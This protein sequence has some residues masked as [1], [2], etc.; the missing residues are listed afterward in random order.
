[1]RIFY[2][3]QLFFTVFSV[4]WIYFGDW[5]HYNLQCGPICYNILLFIHDKILTAPSIDKFVTISSCF[6]LIR[7]SQRHLLTNLLEFYGTHPGTGF[8]TRVVGPIWDQ[9]WVAEFENR[10]GCLVKGGTKINFRP[11]ISVVFEILSILWN[12]YIL[13]MLINL[14]ISLI[15]ISGRKSQ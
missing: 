8:Y 7:Y 3:K 12:L 10:W 6:F 13:Q 14:E 11:K 5:S 9:N 15:L 1:M 4:L 2:Y